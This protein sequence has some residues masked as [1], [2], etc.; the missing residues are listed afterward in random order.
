MLLYDGLF[1]GCQGDFVT[2]FTTKIPSSKRQ[3]PNNNIEIINN[4]QRAISAMPLTLLS[5]ASWREM[6]NGGVWRIE[7]TLDMNLISG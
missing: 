1:E 2:S 4:N 7:E 6:K 5:P 3:I